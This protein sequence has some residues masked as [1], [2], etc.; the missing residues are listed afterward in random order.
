MSDLETFRC[1]IYSVPLT[2][3]TRRIVLVCD[4]CHAETDA[5]PYGLDEHGVMRPSRDIEDAMGA[6]ILRNGWIYDEACG[7]AK[8][9]AICCSEECW[10]ASGGDYE[11]WPIVWGGAA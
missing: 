5:E 10:S 6:L 4:S 11:R 3:E 7:A 8:T 9:P 1:R 2:A